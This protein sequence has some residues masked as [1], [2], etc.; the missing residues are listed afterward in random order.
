MNWHD[1]KRCWKWE[2]H[3]YDFNRSGTIKDHK[4]Q[5]SLR[6]YIETFV[7]FTIHKWYSAGFVKNTHANLHANDTSIF[8]Q[9]KDVT[10]IENVFNKELGNVCNWFIYSKLSVH[11]GEDKTKCIL[12]I[13]DKNLPELNI[14]RNNN[15]TK[16]CR[17]VEYL[18]CYLDTNLSGE[19]I[20]MK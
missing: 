5:S 2:I 9:H 1:F 7:V 8:G 14:T 16:Q 20:A 13:R 6:I 19:S 4:L 10:E 11:F 17:I 15:S 3:G 12:F 18:G